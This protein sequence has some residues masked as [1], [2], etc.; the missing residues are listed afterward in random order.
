MAKNYYWIESDKTNKYR[1][2]DSAHLIKED[3]I[4]YPLYLKAEINKLMKK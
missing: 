1:T 3:A 2:S 4:K